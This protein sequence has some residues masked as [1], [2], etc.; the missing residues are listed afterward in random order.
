MPSK[1]NG[2]T[3]LTDTFISERLRQSDEIQ[4]KKEDDNKGEN[5]KRYYDK[6]SISHLG[7]LLNSIHEELKEIGNKEALKGFE[8]IMNIIG[9]PPDNIIA[10]NFTDIVA[11]LSEKK[12]NDFLRLFVLANKID[13]SNYELKNWINSLINFDLEQ[14]K[15]HLNITEKVLKDQNKTNYEKFN[16]YLDSINKI[17]MSQNMDSK[18]KKTKLNKKLNNHSVI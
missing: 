5:K 2:I 17:V 1:L 18:Q 8:K 15:I 4:R 6:L 7:K 10:L 12:E 9:S 16:G 13:E 3:P 11:A 14:L